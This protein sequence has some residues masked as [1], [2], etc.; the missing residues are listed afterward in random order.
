[1]A[2]FVNSDPTL[3]RLCLSERA[4]EYC[5]KLLSISAAN[6]ELLVN[7]LTNDLSQPVK[8]T[9]L[10]NNYFVSNYQSINK[11]LPNKIDYVEQ[12]PK[13]INSNFASIKL[14]QDLLQVLNKIE[15]NDENDL[16]NIVD[17][18][19]EIFTVFEQHLIQNSKSNAIKEKIQHF[20]YATSQM[21]DY[22]ILF[23]SLIKSDKI[24]LK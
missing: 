20:A 3:G 8:C 16:Y 9:Q 21:K 5:Q 7:I 23:S 12:A 22:Y 4:I 14:I 15:S 10:E 1:M 13:A 18:T 11:W 19:K 2:S 24:G 6:L 17:T